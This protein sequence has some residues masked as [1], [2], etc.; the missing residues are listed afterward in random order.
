MDN[1]VDA[2]TTL[3]N[4]DLVAG[5]YFTSAGGAS[6]SS[7]ARW[8]GTNWS[9]LGS[10]TNGLV[11]ALATLPNGDIVAGGAFT[12]AGGV[13]VAGIARW[14][15]T[16]WSALGS[17][18]DASVNALATLPNG[19]LVAGGWFATAGGVNAS[20]IARWN[21]TN[22]S[23]LGSGMSGF[24]N[25]HYVSSLATLPSGDLVAGGRFT[26]AGGVIASHIA[27]WDGSS[28]ST[29]GSGT[30]NV[31]NALTTLPNGDLMAG[32]MFST[33]GGVVS[34]CV[35]Q[36]TTTCPASTASFG[37]GCTGTSGPNVL[38]AT[39]LPWT[40]STFTA[41]ATGMPAIS[42]ALSVIGF[43]TTSIALSSILPQGVAGCTLWVSPDLLL[44]CVPSAGSVTTQIA[45][46]NAVALAGQ[47]LRQQVVPIELDAVGNI[48]ALT[49]TNALT[50]TIGAF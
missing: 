18:M 14:N 33:A 22:W 43:S 35:A 11:T 1:W 41:V 6:A 28:W 17:G 16:T 48:V 36:L 2:L 30:N 27:R 13:S 34:A 7:I 3:P 39:S 26:V 24:G 46:P 10:G 15:G 42:L 45:I 9:A 44:L 8:D 32:G 23:A 50:L 47:L 38:T 40:G 4:G 31:V 49:S 19:D 25:I 12:S 21:G 20:S 5:G 37:A 29:L